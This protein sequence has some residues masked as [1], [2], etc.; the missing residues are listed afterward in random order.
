MEL[1]KVFDSLD[2]SLA[3]ISML[4]PNLRLTDSLMTCLIRI[5]IHQQ[6]G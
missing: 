3:T 4:K 5:R 1:S 2:L 6:L